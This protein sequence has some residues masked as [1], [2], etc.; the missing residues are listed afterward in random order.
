[1]T[2]FKELAI[3]SVRELVVV[4]THDCHFYSSSLFSKRLSYLVPQDGLTDMFCKP[5]YQK[6]GCML[7]HFYEIF[8]ST[9]KEAS[10]DWDSLRCLTF[11]NSL[12]EWDGQ[13]KMNGENKIKK[14]DMTT[15]NTNNSTY[16]VMYGKNSFQWSVI[17]HSIVLMVLTVQYMNFL[18]YLTSEVNCIS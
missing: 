9:I 10:F 15:W 8:S 17:N 4:S 16:T 5:C 3:S 1:V 12:Y 18:L 2:T 7:F 13:C 11:I 14:R 6:T